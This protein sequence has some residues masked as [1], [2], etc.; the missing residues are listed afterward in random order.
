[1]LMVLSTALSASAQKKKAKVRKT[2]KVEAPQE[3]P[4]FTEMLQNTQRVMIID[5]I[6][7]QREQ[8]LSAILTNSDEG[9]LST[10]TDF[11][12]APGQ[13]YDVVYV[14]EL[15]NR[16]VFSMKDATGQMRLYA[17]DLLGNEWS[18][19]EMLRG[20][21]ENGLTDMG[22]PYLM[23]DGQTL[24]FAARGGNGLGGYDIYHTRLDVESGQYLKPENVGLPF[25]SEA[26]DFLYVVSEQD[27]IGFFATSRRQHEGMVC[28][29]TFV[30]TKNRSVYDIN[31]MGGATVRRMANILK[32]ADTWGNGKRREQAMARLQ[33]MKARAMANKPAAKPK[34]YFSFEVDDH[35]T[36][37]HMRDFRDPD[38]ATRMRELLSMQKMRS[39]MK[40]KL[41]RARND[42]AQGTVLE[43][44]R[45][46]PD[47][48]EQ[49][50]QL[51][52]LTQQ[53]R[54]L[55]KEIRNKELSK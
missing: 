26:D 30:P 7:I 8:L 5:S 4:R 52:Q 36:Y 38:N 37:H 34:D 35:T 31:S 51:H 55:E 24:Y 33:N 3:N 9:R 42:Y 13:A 29:Y 12:H 27:S 50:G 1:M 49:E 14:N 25:N 15:G 32:I 16:C 48:I 46:H 47:I 19:P 43:R 45:L 39:S 54:F 20:L 11:F 40:D 17:C 21:A 18:K 10:Y 28:V 22:F 44:N 6:V 2:A 23:P 53:I 41:D